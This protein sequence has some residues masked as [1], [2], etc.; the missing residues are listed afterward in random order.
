MI[1][2]VLDFWFAAGMEK[3]WFVKDPEFDRLIRDKLLPLYQQASAEKLESWRQHG[4]GSLA[5]CILLDQVPRNLFRNDPRSFATDSYALK[6]AE[7][8]VAKAWDKTL[9]ER[10]KV[11]LYLPFEHS[12]K[13][14]NQE[15]SL[16]LFAGLGRDSNWY[17]YAVKHAEIIRR[18][19]R[20]P[21]RNAV[22]GRENTPEEAAFL[23]EPGS[24][25]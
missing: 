18:F 5:L 24:S 4:R 13:L 19:G 25:F 14:E 12:E 3:R 2:E 7:Q 21:H 22:L 23:L 6:V 1:D 10:E 11:F 9:E 20:F 15:K 17:D 8:A 16:E